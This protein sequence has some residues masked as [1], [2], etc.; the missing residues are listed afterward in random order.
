MFQALL[1]RDQTHIQEITCAFNGI[2]L[3]I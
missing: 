1:Q 2:A 3:R